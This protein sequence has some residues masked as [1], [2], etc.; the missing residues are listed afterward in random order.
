MTIPAPSSGEEPREVAET[1]PGQDHRADTAPEP[2][3][4]VEPADLQF[5]GTHLEPEELAALTAI[6]GK[7]ATAEPVENSQAGGAGPQDRTLL[8][9]RRLGLWG[10][11]GLDSWQHAAGLR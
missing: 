6:I 11:P 8:R 9:R 10:R 4:T 7:L 3:P 2:E 5:S 1:S